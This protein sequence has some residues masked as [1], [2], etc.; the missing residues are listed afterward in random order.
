MVLLAWAFFK[1]AA[2]IDCIRLN[3]DD[4]LC[5][6]LNAQTAGQKK[7][8]HG[9]ADLPR[10]RP[11]E[12]PA[13]AASQCL[14]SRV[15]QDSFDVVVAGVLRVELRTG[16]ECFDDEIAVELSAIIGRFVAV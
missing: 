14:V 13:G 1:F 7:L 8:R 4:C 12:N 16:A 6:I 11:V 3:R 2:R 15:E 9:A 5:N 10:N